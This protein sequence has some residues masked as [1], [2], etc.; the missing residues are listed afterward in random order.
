MPGYP[1]NRTTF[2]LADRAR[3][4]P[5]GSHRAIVVD[6]RRRP[7][8]EHIATPGP[9]P[10]CHSGRHWSELPSWPSPVPLTEFR[11]SAEPSLGLGRRRRIRGHPCTCT[12]CMP[13]HSRAQAGIPLHHRAAVQGDGRVLREEATHHQPDRRRA[14]GGDAAGNG[15][16]AGGGLWCG[17][18]VSRLGRHRHHERGRYQHI[19]GR[20]LH[21]RAGRFDPRQR[22]L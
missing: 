5:L 4:P 16:C 10:L 22:Q 15:A 6:A 2:R 8:Q 12:R 21:R 1:E 9:E 18:G 7:R 19:R 11:R 17:H 3:S 13:S 14:A 20:R